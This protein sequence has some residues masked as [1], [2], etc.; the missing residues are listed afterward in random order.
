[1]D[2]QR[3]DAKESGRLHLYADW[4]SPLQYV[5][6]GFVV[7]PGAS[8]LSEVSFAS[9]VN[10]ALR[11]QAE[12]LQV[13]ALVYRR[14]GSILDGAIRDSVVL[15]LNLKR[16]S[17]LEL[18]LGDPS[19]IVSPPAGRVA[20]R[21]IRFASMTSGCGSHRRSGNRRQCPRRF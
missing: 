10:H 15:D 16:L 18:E 9:T 19:V 5:D 6:L 2:L 14:A 8:E 12:G 13:D 11:D 17:T 3:I 21:A 7:I 4:P 1:M 20:F